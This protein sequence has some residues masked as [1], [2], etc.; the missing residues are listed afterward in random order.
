[1]VPRFLRKKNAS[2]LYFGFLV[3]FP[4]NG[5]NPQWVA[6][7][8][9]GQRCSGTS[10]EPGVSSRFV[11]FCFSPVAPHRTPAMDDMVH[12]PGTPTTGYKFSCAGV[13]DE[14]DDAHGAE[15]LKIV[16]CWLFQPLY[17]CP[18]PVLVKCSF[19]Y[20]SRACLGKMINCLAQNGA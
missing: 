15:N 10:N 8:G 17:V 19:L 16:L 11:S 18:E 20:T 13:E 2:A 1:M 6:K 5:T 9:S 3:P 4:E 7:T 14:G 12:V